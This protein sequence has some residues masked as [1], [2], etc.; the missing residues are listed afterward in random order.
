MGQREESIC[1]F[2]RTTHPVEEFI[3]CNAAITVRSGRTKGETDP[4]LSNR[5]KRADV[6]VTHSTTKTW[7]SHP[8]PGAPGCCLKHRIAHLSAVPNNSF[9]N[10]EPLQGKP[11]THT[12]AQQSLPRQLPSFCA[13]PKSP[14][15]PGSSPARRQRDARSDRCSLCLKNPRPDLFQ[16]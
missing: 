14:A 5:A 8:A 3:D 13:A 4:Y 2:S 12:D 11:Q 10:P 7:K 9:A 16:G 1:R 6:K 15:A